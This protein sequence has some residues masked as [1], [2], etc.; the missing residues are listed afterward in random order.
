MTHL[1]ARSR[2]SGAELIIVA[3]PFA[4]VMMP[5]LGPSIIAA[6]CKARSIRTKVEYSGLRLAE[7]I[8]L[9]LYERIGLSS[10]SLMLGDL[11]FRRLA[12]PG[13]AD[14]R[15]E[16]EEYFANRPRLET[17]STRFGPITFDD[18]IN[19]L[20]AVGPFVRREGERILAQAP[21]IVGFSTVFQQNLSSIALATELKRKRP[22]LMLVVGGANVA[23]PMGS[24]FIRNADCFDYAFSGEAD[25]EFPDFVAD[26]LAGRQHPAPKRTI[27]CAQIVQLDEVEQPCFEDYFD[28]LTQASLEVLEPPAP[29]DTLPIETSRGCW[30]GAKHHCTFCG[31]NGED[32]AFRTKSATRVVQEIE[33]DLAA[34]KVRTF[35][36]TDNIMSNQFRSAVLPLLNRLQPLDL[37]FEVKSNLREDD[38]DQ[39]VMSGVNTIQP[40]IES[41]STAVLKRIEKGVTGIK[42]VWLLRECASRR[43]SVTWNL[44]VDVPGELEVDLITQA[45]L[46]P[47]LVHLQPPNGLSPIVIDR[48]SPYFDRPSAFAINSIRPLDAYSALYP[49]TAQLNE[50]AYHFSA[51]YESAFRR[52]AHGRANIEDAVTNWRQR[53][54]SSSVPPKL[55]GVMLDSNRM[56]V[57]DTR[58]PGET[59]RFALG[60]METH[61]LRSFRHPRRVND[62]DHGQGVDDL[63]K[64][65]MMVELDGLAVSV[66][67]EPEIGFALQ[68]QRMEVP[69]LAFFGDEMDT[70][71][72]DSRRV[73]GNLTVG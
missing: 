1:A 15:S 45:E 72:P 65:R 29:G 64:R 34:H 53:W 43:I 58:N 42:N 21:K 32:M 24:E 48:F 41:F 18:A 50:L 60:A 6:Q 12:F 16:I 19:A 46:L 26:V 31:L 27:R 52:S 67:T 69:Q 38:L 35:Q 44:L 30:W 11:L 36:A 40:G 25:T 17:S 20:D 54:Q 68:V 62:E 23:E 63:L 2:T 13:L 7:S 49:E 59:S 9:S 70:Q 8:G 47:A 5:M 10:F 57:E 55:Y 28:Q 71:P 61:L 66:V 22:D 73:M 33:R 39:F 3:P 4:T 14:P 37:F 56:F 51:N